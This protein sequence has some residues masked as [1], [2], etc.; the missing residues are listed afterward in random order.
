MTE[1]SELYAQGPTLLRRHAAEAF[2]L[3]SQME[4][5]LS[6]DRI[7]PVREGDRVARMGGLA[8]EHEQVGQQ[9]G[10]MTV[11]NT[12]PVRDRVYGSHQHNGSGSL[13]GDGP[14][15]GRI[16]WRPSSSERLSP[17][18]EEDEILL[19]CEGERLARLYRE[20]YLPGEE[21]TG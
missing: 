13:F 19:T 7:V 18:F 10:R 16:L 14:D 4:T 15:S 2:A 11:G 3:A 1:L 12:R 17:I 20:R 6:E 9:L 5:A 21:G 8:Y